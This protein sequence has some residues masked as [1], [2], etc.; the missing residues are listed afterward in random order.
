[1]DKKWIGSKELKVNDK[2]MYN[3]FS[4]NKITNITKV[5][6]RGTYYNLEVMDNHNYYVSDKC[7]LVHNAKYSTTRLE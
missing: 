2:V 5:S 1:M 4:L 7:V 6:E 3:D